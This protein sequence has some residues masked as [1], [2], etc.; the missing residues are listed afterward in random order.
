MSALGDGSDFRAMS[1]FIPGLWHFAAAM[2]FTVALGII[3][4][5]EPVLW[6]R[7][8]E[9]LA[10]LVIASCALFFI[11]ESLARKGLMKFLHYPLPDWDVLLLGPASHRH[12]LTHSPILP[13]LL[14]LLASRYPVLMQ[15]SLPF[16]WSAAGLSVGIGSHL[17][18]DC[19]GSRS[20]KIVVVPYWFA[21]RAAPSRLYLLAGAALCLGAGAAFSGFGFGAWGLDAARASTSF[22]NSTNAPSGKNIPRHTS[23]NAQDRQ[24]EQAAAS[25][26]LRPQTPGLEPQLVARG[27][28]FPEGPAVAA[29]GTVFAVDIP[30]GRIVRVE[31]DRCVEWLNTSLP[32]KDGKPAMKGGPN[33]SRFHGQM[34]IV[35]DSGRKQVLAIGPDKSIT[36]LADA[37]RGDLKNGPNDCAF[38]GR[39]NFYFT[40][41]V[42]DGIGSVYLCRKNADGRT[43]TTTEFAAGFHFPNGVAVSD[44][45]KWVYVAE[46]QRNRI[47]KIERKADGSAGEKSVWCNLPPSNVGPDGMAF[48]DRGR[49]F[50]AHFGAG[51][52]QVIGPDGK[53]M[54][55][56]NAGGKN[57][58]N[59]AFSRDFKTLYVTETETKAIYKIDLSPLR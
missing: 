31:G 33:G 10:P 59:V 16:A 51:A 34:L 15:P 55:S 3:E 58:T 8:L 32:A 35:C 53:V 54:A 42:W 37:A 14:L 20:H 4:A 27:V 45:D 19:V 30:T 6:L 40:D 18:W 23:M 50:V 12:W 13:A 7:R 9:F 43:Y 21:L 17:F 5:G 2:A 22:L 25:T 56:L 49:L 52:V 24:N 36:V 28:E 38:D 39:G 57:P 29:D 26:G 44:D 47:W 48:D 11:P 41:P 1:Y 46:T